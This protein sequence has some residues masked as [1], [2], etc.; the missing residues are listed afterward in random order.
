MTVIDEAEQLIKDKHRFT[1]LNG[2]EINYVLERQEVILKLLC[3]TLQ[4]L[5]VL[6]DDE[7]EKEK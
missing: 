3:L 5:S 6:E 2:H 4:K 1:G 7:K